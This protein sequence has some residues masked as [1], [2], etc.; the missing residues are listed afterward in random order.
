MKKRRAHGEGTI[1]RRDDGRWVAMLNVGVIAG[2]RRRRAF[3]GATQAQA[4]AKLNDAT[5]SMRRGVPVPLERQTFGAFAEKWL[6]TVRPSLR[7]PTFRRYS[8]LL[9]HAV[10]ALGHTSL[11]KLGPADLQ[12][13]YEDR[14]KAGAAPRTI[15]H[16]HRVIH[17]A[18][19]D[20]ERWGEVARN[21]ARLADAPRVG[22]AEMRTLTA[23]E[24]RQLMRSAEGD[25]LEAVVVLALTTGM[26]M[27]EL[28]G[29]TWRA[30]DLDKGAV[31]VQ[32]SMQRTAAGL[33]LVEP[34]TARS[35]RQI[36]VEPRVAAVLR[37]HRAL[38]L[39]ERLAAGQEWVDRDLVF[40]TQEGGPIDGRE[41][42]RAWFRPLL[43]RAGLP[44][45]RFHDLRH[46][47][48]SIALAQ[49]LHPKV[50]QEAMGHSTIAVTM[51]LYSHVVPSLQREA[52][53]EMGAA[54]F[55]A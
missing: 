39:Q 8:S 7:E 49:G 31:R 14:R 45:I 29:L 2:R 16:V 33:A 20:A 28:L 37:R 35:R 40:T 36:E 23:V 54:L 10:R 55:G 44:A 41:L 51:D 21:V 53:R 4:L 50:V 6:A 32:A 27:G 25:R 15:L 12:R 5:H 22:R 18:L 43:A 30:T 13:L 38:Q 9:A 47:Y 11:A 24:A 48:A 3:Y 42:L 26:R 19:R 34:K 1:Y 46:S 17:R 52:A